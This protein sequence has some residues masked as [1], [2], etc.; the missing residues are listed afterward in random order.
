MNSNFLEVPY[1]LSLQEVAIKLNE[2]TPKKEKMPGG[3]LSSA[4]ILSHSATNLNS[5]HKLLCC[6]I[7]LARFASPALQVP[8]EQKETI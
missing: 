6:W 4:K 3:T 5:W 2:L 7:D 8:E 1:I